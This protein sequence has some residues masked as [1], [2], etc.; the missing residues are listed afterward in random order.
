MGSER[1]KVRGHERVE[2]RS[3]RSGEGCM[4]LSCRSVAHL[5]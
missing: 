4:G 3:G 1:E 5:V 2:K